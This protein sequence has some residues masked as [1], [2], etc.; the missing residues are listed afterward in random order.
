MILLY[1][2]NINIF[3]IYYI[4]FF[5]RYLMCTRCCVITLLLHYISGVIITYYLHLCRFK[6]P[7]EGGDSSGKVTL[8]RALKMREGVAGSVNL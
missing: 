3:F 4:I 6:S 5:T 8:P 1:S 2:K 7:P